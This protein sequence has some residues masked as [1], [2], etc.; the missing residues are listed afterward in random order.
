VIQPNQTTTLT[1]NNAQEPNANTTTT[2]RFNLP[3]TNNPNIV[4]RPAEIDTFDPNV[5]PTTVCAP[6]ETCFG[7]VTHYNIPTGYGAGTTGAIKV[8]LVYDRTVVPFVRLLTLR[9]WEIRTEGDSP[10]GT[11]KAATSKRIPLCR[12]GRYNGT[13]CVI[14][15]TV[16]PFARTVDGVKAGPFDLVAQFWFKTTDDPFVKGH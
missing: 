15:W 10:N 2:S 16:L 11:V 12:L 9:W 6:P 5:T 7:R 8:T 1:T 4:G 14:I 13:T 3:P